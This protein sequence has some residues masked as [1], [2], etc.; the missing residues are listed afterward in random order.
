MDS[1]DVGC[2]A[3]NCR[4]SARSSPLPCVHWGLLRMGGARDYVNS[5][6]PSH[7]LTMSRA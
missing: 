7:L 1:C 2:S 5:P 3:E 4:D 6:P